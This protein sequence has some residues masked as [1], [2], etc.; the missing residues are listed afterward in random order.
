M[1][2]QS[3][4]SMT[5]LWVSFACYTLAIVGVGL[6]SAR[7]AR[8]SD[9]DYFLAGRSLGSWVAALS[10]SASS[11]SGWV[12]LGLV[13]WAFANGVEAY[14]IV[15]GCLCGFLFNWFV[16]AGRLSDQSR[17]LG[18]LTVPDYFARKFRERFPIV[19]I[20]SVVVI[21]TAMMLYVAAQFAAA[22]KSF[23][24]ISDRL[25]Y[26][27]GVLMGGAIVLVYTVS[28]GFRAVCWTD[29][30]QALLMVGTL[31]VF[32]IYLLA[33]E[34]GYGP[35]FDQLR[36]VNP[37]LLSFTPDKA[38]LAFVGFLL[39]AGA[40]GINFGYPGQPHVLVRFLSLKSRKEI[41]AGGI[42]SFVWGLLVYWGAVTVGLVAREMAARGAD[43]AQVML[44]EQTEQQELALVLSAMHLLPGVLSGLVLAAVL[45]AICS[46]ADSQLVVAGSSVAND[47]YSRLVDKTGRTAHLVLNRLTIL[48]LGVVAVLLV[49]NQEVKVY[50]YVLTYGWAVLG[51]SFGPQMILA[52]LWRRASYAGC[53][54]GML[55]G[56]VLAIVWKLAFDNTIG[57]V[58]VYNLPLAFAA[59]LLVNVVV[60]L[61]TPPRGSSPTRGEGG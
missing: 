55:T 4:V 9:E 52:L 15:P 29:F 59:A 46:T 14:W 12:T 7:F 43:W 57:G 47:L 28:G 8:R 32:P 24:A 56:F 37:A 38:G 48:A 44:N 35:T 39:G 51:A 1:L 11:E 20:L 53:V 18:A 33:S 10:A 50:T 58:E 31:V 30:L 41:V 5:T 36:Q 34:G 27:V 26:K 54:A 13:G 23:S 60:S 40:L 45:A 19:R 3:D 25:D 6:Y 21:L 22:G 17:E 2:A 49:I 61:L 16:I 42:I